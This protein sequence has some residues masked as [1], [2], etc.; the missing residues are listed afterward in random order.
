M[1]LQQR[2]AVLTLSL[3]AF[4]MIL[5]EFS[6]ISLLSNIA[7]QL[8]VPTTTIGH[9]VSVYAI[10][11]ATCGLLTPFLFKTFE[12]KPLIFYTFTLLLISNTFTIYSKNSI[13]FFIYRALCAMSHG[14]FWAL[15]TDYAMKIVSEKH[16][17]L[18]SSI[19]FSSIPLATIIGIPILNYIG[20]QFSWGSA[21]FLV[22]ILIICCMVCIFIFLPHRHHKEIHFST[23]SSAPNTQKFTWLL[24]SITAM[25]AT[26]Q[27]CA[28]TYIEPYIRSLDFFS[29]RHLTV[30]LLLFG[31]SGLIGNILTMYFMSR[32]IKQLTLIFL[33]I[34]SI[35]M[36]FIYSLGT[37]ISF[38][39]CALLLCFWGI[40]ASILF[41][42]IQTW[43]I[44]ASKQHSTTMAAFNSAVLNYA[45][46]FGAGLGAF[47][48]SHLGLM[49]I[50]IFSACI[51]LYATIQLSLM[52]IK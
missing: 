37:H 36:F 43:V 25:L 30:L 31:L 26:A 19:I 11:G 39:S 16:R 15:V 18:T 29:Q 45:I 38:Y 41:T 17:T 47:V 50:F 22:S 52:T 6:P 3:C 7:Q 23:P 34:F 44:I 49:S 27:F 1:H 21:F 28:Y 46:A 2:C 4:T 10:I 33:A 24:I 5:I 35:A 48:L 12:R 9:T 8:H 32:Y 40:S 51:L 42:T 13:D 20:Q 14:I